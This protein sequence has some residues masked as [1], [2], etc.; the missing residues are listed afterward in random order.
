MLVQPELVRRSRLLPFRFVTA[1]DELEKWR[2]D[3]RVARK[4]GNSFWSRLV[5]AYK[6]I[7][8]P[9][10]PEPGPVVDPVNLLLESLNRAAELALANVPKLEGKTL[11][12]VDGSGSMTWKDQPIK[13]ASLFAAVIL[14]TNPEADLMM[15]DNDALYLNV[16]SKNP[17]LVLQRQIRSEEGR[18]GKESRSRWLPYH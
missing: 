12:A 6:G 5:R 14:R 8:E 9:V 15:F 13:I 2:E 18:V 17:I 16:K 7:P 4:R 10:A 11:V 3:R 1:R